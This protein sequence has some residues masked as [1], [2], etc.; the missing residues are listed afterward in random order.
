MPLSFSLFLSL[1]LFL[2]LP[3]SF[4]LFFSLS[5]FLFL[6]LSL[7]FSPSLSLFLSLYVSLY[8][9]LSPTSSIATFT[10]NPSP[11]Q[12]NTGSMSVGDLVAVNSMLLQLSIPFN[13]MGFTC[14][15]LYFSLFLTLSYS[16]S[17]PLT[18]SHSFFCSLYLSLILHPLP[19]HSDAI[20]LSL[21]QIKS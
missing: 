3:L 9:S 14:K 8:Q 2:S 19:S 7:S 4:F 6:S 1:C 5:P 20:S 17:F 15:S 21:H 11:Q 18:C 13:W 12:V 16:F 10:L